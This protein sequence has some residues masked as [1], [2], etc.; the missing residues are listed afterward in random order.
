MSIAVGARRQRLFGSI[1]YA[2]WLCYG[3][4]VAVLIAAYATMLS[5]GAFPGVDFACFRAASL[6]LAHGGNPYD[7]AQLW[8]VE[9][10]LYNLPHHV[11]PGTAAY[12]ALDRYYNPPLFA[13]LLSP[14]ARLPYAVGYGIYAAVAG[15]LAALGSWL[16]VPSLGWTRHRQAAMALTLVSPCVFLTVWNGQQST[17]LLAAL[18]LALYALRRG[19]P[20]LAG[21]A[22]AL[23]WVKP[24]LLV[25]IA[26][27]VPLVGLS[28]RAMLRMY[29]G[30]AI[31]T[32][33]GLVATAF[34]R[35]T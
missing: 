6:V 29:G 15:A 3:V 32:M 11:R 33:L 14:L 2:H 13:T 24:H 26:L 30:F 23:G 35:G 31:T 12:Y 19:H 16:V 7:F 10:A 28:G 25:P 18:G 22:L 34:L 21:A 27:A 8:R 1:T 20:G 5:H 9:N 4:L 17:L